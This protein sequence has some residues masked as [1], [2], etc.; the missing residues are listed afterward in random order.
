MDTVP[1][2][3]LTGDWFD[4]CKCDIPCPC[5]FAQ[6]PTGNACEGVLAWHI[7]EGQ[8]GD[9]PLAGL[10]LLALAAFRGNPWAGEAKATMGLFIDERADERQREALQAIFGGQ[11]GGWPE[12]FAGLI[13]EMRGVEFAPIACEIAADLAS[14]RAEIP[15]QVVARVE[16][17]TGPTTPAGQRVQ[18]VNP[19][20]SEVGPG[21]VATWGKATANRAEAFG[22]KWE[23][24]GKS[25]KHI[26]FNW[27]GP[28]QP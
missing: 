2:W 12:Q 5:E 13:G 24:D 19:P 17:L 22:F 1:R 28:G 15:G 23:W 26:P 8:Y 18:L 9:V 6:A 20:G 4:V 21:G 14:W 10:N 16:A 27:S 11:A 25:S 7:R 3:H